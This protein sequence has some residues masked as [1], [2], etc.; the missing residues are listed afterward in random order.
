M[1][2]IVTKAF[3]HKHHYNHSNSATQQS[4]S[5]GHKPQ[6]HSMLQN[7]RTR[8]AGNT[9]LISAPN[10]TSHPG[11]KIN[12]HSIPKAL[13]KSAADTIAGVDSTTDNQGTQTTVTSES[14][15]KKKLY[16]ACVEFEGV[17]TAMLLKSGG[18][19]EIKGYLQQASGESYFNDMLADERGKEYAKQGT[20]GVGMHLFH[21][22]AK[23]LTGLSILK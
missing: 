10:I 18:A 16:D 21:F 22:L 7:C 19:E 4:N 23:N 13:A 17:F 15:E 8:A 5:A 6:F 14:G 1:D 12:T 2:K 9:D 11:G 3:S 20:L